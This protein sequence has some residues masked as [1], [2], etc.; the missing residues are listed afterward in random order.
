[1]RGC[2]NFWAPLSARQQPHGVADRRKLRR[3]KVA[4][5]R[6]A[7]GTAKPTRQVRAEN[8]RRKLVSL[9]SYVRD[10]DR[11]LSH[12]P[13]IRAFLHDYGS[14]TGQGAVMVEVSGEQHPRRGSPLAFA[15]AT[16]RRGVRLGERRV[17]KRT[18]ELEF[19]KGGSETRRGT[20]QRDYVRARRPTAC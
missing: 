1:M 4:L 10:T 8:D 7:F 9:Y 20:E 15:R 2:T 17:M 16:F 12:L 13:R 6:K 18:P 14:P 11:F 5:G 19:L 3:D